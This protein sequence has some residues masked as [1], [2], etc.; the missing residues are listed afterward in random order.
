MERARA[1]GRTG[2]DFDRAAGEP[3]RLPRLAHARSRFHREPHE[4]RGRF[5]AARRAR[6]V[7]VERAWLLAVAQP[8]EQLR[9]RE[10][11]P[12]ER[13]PGVAAIFGAVARARRKR[14]GAPAD[15]GG[16]RASAR[17]GC[18]K[19]ERGIA[20]TLFLCRGRSDAAARRRGR[21]LDAGPVRR[22]D[23]RSRRHDPDRRRAHRPLERQ[24]RAFVRADDRD[25]CRPH[26]RA[27]SGEKRMAADRSRRD[28]GPRW[29]QSHRALRG[30]GGTAR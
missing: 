26:R 25:R 7:A 14:R 12:G 30:T 20:R 17:R 27:L 10:P 2:H 4:R 24:R 18:A 3:R 6:I 16:D 28:R 13:E 15:A 9:Q 1:L 11:G 19:D 29:R 8:D 23:G 21:E 22:S 5:A